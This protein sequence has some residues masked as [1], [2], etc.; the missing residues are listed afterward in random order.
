MSH[1][2]TVGGRSEGM[3][4]EQVAETIGLAAIVTEQEHRG[5][6]CLLRLQEMAQTVDVAALEA[7]ARGAEIRDLARLAAEPAA[8]IV[9]PDPG[10]GDPEVLQ[11]PVP[12]I[13]RRTDQLASSC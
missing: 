5:L 2:G 4:V 1:P 12:E 6:P 11:A 8:S 10:L 9:T 3:L 13:G 7:R